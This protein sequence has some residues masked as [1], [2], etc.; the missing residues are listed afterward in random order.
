M[1]QNPIVI[2]KADTWPIR[3][4]IISITL[5]QI[6]FLY[7]FYLKL[8][9]SLSP[10]VAS[11]SSLSTFHNDAVLWCSVRPIH[12]YQLALG[13]LPHLSTLLWSPWSKIL[14]DWSIPLAMKKSL[15]QLPLPYLPPVIKIYHFFCC[16]HCMVTPSWTFTT[17]SF[18]SLKRYCSVMVLRP[19]NT[20][21]PLFE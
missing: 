3:C 13:Y 17:F 6:G 18:L 1:L 20:F 9:K 10:Q 2:V 4:L 8:Q 11:V 19:W 16:H 5:C 21:L 7:W 12:H 14:S 15:S